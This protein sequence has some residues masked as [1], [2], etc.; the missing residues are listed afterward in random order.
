[1]DEL[2]SVVAKE[3]DLSEDIYKLAVSDYIIIADMY[4]SWLFD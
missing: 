2:K 3:L 4:T 1:M